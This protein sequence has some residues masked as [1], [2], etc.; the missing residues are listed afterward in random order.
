MSKEPAATPKVISSKSP[1]IL[2]EVYNKYVGSKSQLEQSR[3]QFVSPLPPTLLEDFVLEEREKTTA[4]GDAETIAKLFPKTY[5]QKIVMLTKSSKELAAPFHES[6]TQK[7]LRVGVVLSGGPSP[8]GH[9]LLCV[10]LKQ[11]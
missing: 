8:G 10:C 5:G 3:L 6:I 2:D 1:V 9:S 7:E 11:F 4:A